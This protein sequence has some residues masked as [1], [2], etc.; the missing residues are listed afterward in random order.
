MKSNK[1]SVTVKSFTKKH[2]FT[3]EE[4]SMAG[5]DLITFY[6]NGNPILKCTP[7]EFVK[8]KRLFANL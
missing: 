5:H 3:I 2:T 8:L 7:L 4:T 1:K 6:K